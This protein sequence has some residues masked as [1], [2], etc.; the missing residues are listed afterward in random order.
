[1]KIAKIKVDKP[2]GL[3][4][5]ELLPT[6]YE[7]WCPGCNNYHY[8]IAGRWIWNERLLNPTVWPGIINEIGDDEG[9]CEVYINQ[10]ELIYSKDCGH[11][12]K[13][14]VI[15]MKTIG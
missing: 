9:K 12:L 7:F 10:G 13:G 3:K 8:F 5:R 6:I 1:M 11:A 15:E 14:L 2:F 4:V